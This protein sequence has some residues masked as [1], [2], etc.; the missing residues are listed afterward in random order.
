MKIT[1]VIGLVLIIGSSCFGQEDSLK[2]VYRKK[3]E[4][5][6]LNMNQEEVGQILG[7]PDFTYSYQQHLD[8]GSLATWPEGTD[9]IWLYGAVC[10]QCPANLGSVYFYASHYVQYIFIDNK[11]IG[12][13]PE[14]K[15]T[16]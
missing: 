10:Q 16:H 8:A 9:V 11:R 2:A 1:F 7:K 3:F 6:T 12:V 14:N 13:N 5:V 4:S 15:D